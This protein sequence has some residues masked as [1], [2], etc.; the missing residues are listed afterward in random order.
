MK[1]K[2][3]KHIVYSSIGA[4]FI[5]GIL[6]S[7]NSKDSQESSDK[8]YQ[9]HVKSNYQVFSLNVPANLTFC[10][11]LVP[12]SKT[13]VLE[14]IDRELLVNTYWQSQTLLFIKRAHKWFPI[15]EP[16]LKKNNIPDDFKYLALIESG[17]T[18]AVSPA[19]ATGYWQLMPDAAKEL[20]LEMSSEVDERYDV[21]KSTEAACKYL[22]Q[23]YNKLGNWTLAA[24]SY[25]M[26]VSGVQK[27]IEF[28]KVNNYY[29][30][31]LNQ[32]TSRYVFRIMAI[33]EI[34]INPENYGF[35]VRDK[36]LYLEEKCT[37]VQV[38][39]TISNLVDFSIA[40]NMTYKELKRLNPW[41]RDNHLPNKTKKTYQI[42]IADS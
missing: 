15:I 25:N 36:D 5:L 41:L 21:E 27:Q 10:N 29:D 30:L 26:G 23:A 37:T 12:T 32:E 28:Q 34:L 19:G 17:L 9:N 18:N 20:G 1:N 22:Q 39:S 13:D 42:K 33:K 8:D 11:E 14:S 7:I 35:Y 4:F 6:F 38:D 3:V 31:Y 40:N 16:I 2:V 24:A